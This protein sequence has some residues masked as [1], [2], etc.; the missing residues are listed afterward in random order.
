MPHVPGGLKLSGSYRKSPRTPPSMEAPG[1][2]VALSSTCFGLV[3]FN[4]G[5]QVQ[6]CYL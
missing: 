3:V 5:F 4:E 2:G 1:I 6:V